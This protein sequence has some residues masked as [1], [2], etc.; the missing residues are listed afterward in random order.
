[1]LFWYLTCV[2]RMAEQTYDRLEL[3]KIQLDTALDLFLDQRN[4]PAAITLAG[5]AENIF[6]RALAIRGSKAALKSA[7]DSIAET[8]QILYKEKL[9]EK[10]FTSHKNRIRDALKHLQDKNG[11]PT[12]TVDLENAACWMLVRAIH[13]GKELG[14]EF[15]RFHEFDNWFYENIVGV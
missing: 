12:V 2:T 7:Y 8:H 4:S 11:G 6:G 3:A 13:N 10:T 14:F 5:A 9:D 15:E 1:M